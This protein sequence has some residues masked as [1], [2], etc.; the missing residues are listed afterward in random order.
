MAVLWS[1]GV[2]LA[3]KFDDI[4]KSV[5]FY[6]CFLR[7]S[8]M[9]STVMVVNISCLSGRILLKN[10][11]FPTGLYCT[12]LLRSLGF[13]I[14]SQLLF[15]E[16]DKMGL[17]NVKCEANGK[18]VRMLGLGGTAC[19]PTSGDQLY[20]KFRADPITRKEAG[21]RIHK[22]VVLGIRGILQKLFSLLDWILRTEHATLFERTGLPF[23]IIMDLPQWC[24]CKN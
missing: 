22:P 8:L 2:I 17:P 20:M 19:R 4:P 23:D 11:C 1:G 9:A 14:Y 7:C 5:S 16:L 24:Q 12:L 3:V 13:G 18:C 21:K 6:D 15:I 10:V